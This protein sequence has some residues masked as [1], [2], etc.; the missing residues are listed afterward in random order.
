MI[1]ILTDKIMMHITDI[2]ASKI[3]DN[4]FEN[5]GHC[6]CTCL[7]Y[8]ALC[9]IHSDGV[10]HRDREAVSLILNVI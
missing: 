10:T 3:N 4:M 6:F 5:T 7:H 1:T 9:P 2:L 8:A